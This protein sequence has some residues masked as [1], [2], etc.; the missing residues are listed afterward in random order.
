MSHNT[1]LPRVAADCEGKECF[2]WF[3]DSTIQWYFYK[4]SNNVANSFLCVFNKAD[5]VYL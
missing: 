2:L 3:Y 1:Y 4:V 5:L